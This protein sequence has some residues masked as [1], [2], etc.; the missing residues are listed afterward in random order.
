MLCLFLAILELVKR[1]VVQLAQK[2]A[3][4]DIYV[5]RSPNFEEKIGADEAIAAVEQEYS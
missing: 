3:F 1:Q 5:K 4:G 2:E